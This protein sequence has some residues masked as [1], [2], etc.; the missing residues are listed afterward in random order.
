[1]KHNLPM[2]LRSLTLVFL[3]ITVATAGIFTDTVTSYATST[4]EKLD[5]T[6]SKLDEMKE[7][8]DI[9][10]ADL[11]ALNDKLSDASLK[12]SEI[13]EQI[14][15]NQAKINQLEIDIADATKFEE[16][17]Y[18]AM[19]LRIK[20]MYENSTMSSALALLF[21]SDSLND[22]LTRSEYISK[23][24]Q[25]DREMLEKYHENKIKLQSDKEALEA[26]K[27]ELEALKTEAAKSE[28]DIKSLV[29]DTQTKIDASTADIEAAEKKALEYEQQIQAEIIAQQEA[30][31]KAIEEAAK[32]AAEEA[33]KKAAE[34]AAKKATEDD[35]QKVIDDANKAAEETAKKAETNSTLYIQQETIHKA[36]SYTNQ[37]LDMLAAIVECEAGN[38]PYEGRLAVASVVLNRVNNPRWPNTISEVLY[39]ANQFT[40]VKSGRF[41]IV[42]A[43]GTC[44]ECRK[45]AKEALDGHINIDA[46][47]FHVVQPGETGGTVIQDHIFF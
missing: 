17:Q 1:M 9:L 45:A 37:E 25:Y 8:R 29:N 31:R 38:Q 19:K 33:A 15:D 11:S 44:D 36:M 27:K 40:P 20:F 34:E 23:I 30:E 35:R 42:L 12:L 4:Q 5:E 21:E 3:C 28:A 41:A 26:S 22:I 13:T 47:F 16:Q 10:T 32:K 7:A 39:Q 46:Y 18:E 14:D 43:R 6:N 2:P 24:S